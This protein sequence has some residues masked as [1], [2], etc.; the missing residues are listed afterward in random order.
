MITI[1]DT[2]TTGLF[3]RVA[4]GQP[5]VPAD[6]PRQPWMASLCALLCE[7]DG[8]EVDHFYE[9]VK[10]PRHDPK[11]GNLV[12]FHPKATEANKLTWDICNARGIEPKTAHDRWFDY[13]DRSSLLVF[14]N[15]Q[16]DSKVLRG[17]CR[18][19][20]EPE[21]GAFGF[22]RKLPTF[23]VMWKGTALCKLEPTWLM[24][25]TGRHYN[26]QAK[27]SECAKLI[28]EEDHE[29]AHDALAD[30]RMTAKLYRFMHKHGMVEPRPYS[31]YNGD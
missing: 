20:G 1:T 23:D 2:E 6:D 16:F 31:S 13:Q 28:L 11:H 8:T 25:A 22:T 3:V 15:T 7:D 29:G 17:S 9:L 19:N 26:K 14:Y 12:D 4:K 21:R 5:P 10:L 24:H 27:L 18:R 30:A